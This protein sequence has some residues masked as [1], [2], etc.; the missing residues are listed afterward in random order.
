M[1]AYL[2]GACQAFL[3][4]I[5]RSIAL[6]KHR[7]HFFIYHGALTDTGIGVVLV[8]IGAVIFQHGDVGGG[9]VRTPVSSN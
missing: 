6:V 1:N 9:I 7:R 5:E 8:D 4:V 2:L 3:T